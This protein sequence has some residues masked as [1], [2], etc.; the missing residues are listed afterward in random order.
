M[1]CDKC[2]TVITKEELGV[3][4]QGEDYNYNICSRCLITFAES[5]PDCNDEFAEL[6]K[7]SVAKD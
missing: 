2:D 5:E 3:V 6:E 7:D 1:K 4:L